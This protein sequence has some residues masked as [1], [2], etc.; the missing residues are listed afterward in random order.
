MMSSSIHNLLSALTRTMPDVSVIII[1]YN[2]F[3]LT[4]QCIRSVIAQTFDVSY[5]VILVDNAS[6]EI[7]ADKF[8]EIFPTIRLVKN[9]ENE[10][11]ARGNNRGLE[12]AKGDY[13]LLLNS[14][15]I[16]KNNAIKIGYDKLKGSHDIGALSCKLLYPDERVQ[17]V[18]GRFP[19]VKRELKDLLRLTKRLSQDQRADFY[20]GT[21]FDYQREREVDWIWGTFFFFPRKALSAFDGGKLPADYFMYMEDVLWCYRLKEAGY[22]IVYHPDGE[23]YHLI[24]GSSAQK[25]QDAFARYSKTILPNEYQF[26]RKTKGILYT[27]IYYLIKALNHLSLRTKTDLV[28]SKTFF[29]QVFQ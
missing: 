9:P 7:P 23:V 13:L 3:E 1:N 20:L 27:K 8:L 25:G 17:P 2:T 4:T 5:E 6:D 12:V 26:I 14:D 28:K 19:D 11:F 15:T 29:G 24:A 16:L 22:R 18:A 21:E 10:G